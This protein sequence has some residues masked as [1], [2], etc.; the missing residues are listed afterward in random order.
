M[1]QCPYMA[2]GECME[3]SL[4]LHL[5]RSDVG[6]LQLRS[7]LALGVAGVVA[8]AI[9][10]VVTATGNDPGAG[11]AV[12]RATLVLL[13]IAVG[14]A[15]WARP[16][17]R[18][19]GYLLVAGGFVTFLGS[20]GGSD[21]EVVYSVGRVS[22]W[23]A[24]VALVYLVLAFPSGRLSH[25]FD[26]ALAGGVALVALLLFVPTALLVDSY[27]C[28]RRGRPAPQDARATRSSS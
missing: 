20:L 9:T 2:S 8:A 5:P 15:M 26:S 13:P 1:R 25:R 7:V 22:A 28:P 3:H 14:L 10:G 16:P 18:R 23:F 19:F 21:D 6:A 4:P 12:A 17:S 11:A 24:E 27:P